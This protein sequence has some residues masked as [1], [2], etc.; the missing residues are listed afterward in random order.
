MTKKMKMLGLLAIA[1]GIVENAIVAEEGSVL[2][3]LKYPHFDKGITITTVSYAPSKKDRFRGVIIL[4]GN[5]KVTKK[6]Q[7]PTNYS[8]FGTLEI[9]KNGNYFSLTNLGMIELSPDGK[10]IS[11]FN[12]LKISKKERQICW[13]KKLENGNVLLGVCAKVETDLKKKGMD[14]YTPIGSPKIIEQTPG[15]KI[16]KEITLEF[17]PKKDVATHQIRDIKHLSNG[18]F[19][20]A[21]QA[22]NKVNEY[23]P[24]GKLFKT[25]YDFTYDKDGKKNPKYLLRGAICVDRC[26]NGNTII[27]TAEG[28]KAGIFEV[29]T[30]GEIVWQLIKGDIPDLMLQYPTMVKKLKNGNILVGNN[31]G[32]MRK[33]WHGIGV[34]EISPEKKIIH[35]ITDH[36]LAYS[37]F[38][39]IVNE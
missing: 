25:I 10:L 1:V 19:L 11:D 26:D 17:K 16:V 3:E 39:V 20:V 8:P 13:G 12:P 36:N 24:D 34:F 29:D 18:N 7:L 14:K 32:H 23:T 28:T 15:G 38:G 22:A 33:G 31:H 27:G 4:D 30:N 21:H 6:V 9:L 5:G 37:I 2:P 35:A